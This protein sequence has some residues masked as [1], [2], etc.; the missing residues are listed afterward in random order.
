MWPFTRKP[1]QRSGPTSWDL[2]AGKVP[3]DNGAGVPVNAPVAE[4]LSAAFASVQ[5]VSQ[6]LASLPLIIYRRDSTGARFEA[7]THPVARL[8]AGDVNEHQTASDFIELMMAS[9]LW[10]GNAFAAIVRDA[11]GRPSSLIPYN[12]LWVSVS[13]LY[14][15]RRLRYDVTDPWGRTRTLLQE[16]LLHVRDRS[17]DGLIGRS[18]LDRA[19]DAFGTAIATESFA[20]NTYRNGARL[21]GVLMHPEGIGEVGRQNIKDFFTQLFS[22][23]SKA[24]SVAVLEE[25]MKWQSISVP[26]EQAELLESRRFTVEAVARLFGVPSQL[27]GST[28]KSNYSNF[29]E[30]SRH[31]A[32]FT[33]APW[34]VRWE[35]ALARSL[36]SEADRGTHEIEINLDELLRGDPLQRAQTWRV[37]REIGAVN[38]NE[39]RRAEGWNP[40]TD[41]DA[42]AYLSPLNMTSSG[43]AAP[44]VA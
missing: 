30:A 40:R 18:R 11:S 19:R 33:I 12:P 35:Q 29:V 27:I 38:A 43:N 3:L 24:G 37:L 34:A 5:L 13:L 22:G 25:G 9:L 4:N 1:E 14:G 16:E 8:F 7:P 26:P 39:V 42:D 28:E 36:F 15:T 2:M 44:G 21:S 17:D 20:A 31:F 10:H 41:P 32:R 6:T 23:S